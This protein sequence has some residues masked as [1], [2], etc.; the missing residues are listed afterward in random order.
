MKTIAILCSLFV[1]LFGLAAAQDKPA[2]GDGDK[3]ILQIALTVVVEDDL[4]GF[5]KLGPEKLKG[6]AVEFAGAKAIIEEVS[7]GKQHKLEDG[8]NLIVVAIPGDALD[9]EH[10][11]S[12][13]MPHFGKQ[14]KKWS[15]NSKVRPDFQLE[16]LQNN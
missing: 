2:P 1:G 9:G 10:D 12:I 7:N 16:L 15:L 11:L 14:T 13:S 5:I 3:H 6:L 4:G 8:Q